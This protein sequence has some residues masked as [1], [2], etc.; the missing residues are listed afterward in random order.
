MNYGESGLLIQP[1]ALTLACASHPAMFA[2]VVVFG[3]AFVHFDFIYTPFGT[4]GRADHSPIEH[5]AHRH[6]SP[7]T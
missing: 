6:L 5:F 7:K 2:V 1:H 4:L 3:L